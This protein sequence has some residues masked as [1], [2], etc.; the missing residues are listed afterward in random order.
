[1]ILEIFIK[2]PWSLVD[3][4]GRIVIDIGTYVGDSAIYFVLKGAKKV[5]AVEPHPKAYEEMLEN[6]RLNKMED[7]IV[8]VNAGLAS[9]PGFIIIENVDIES[10]SGTYY[11][12]GQTGSIKAITLEQLINQLNINPSNTILKMDCEGCEYDVIINDYEHV[13][14][15]RE[16]IMEYHENKEHRLTDINRLLSNDYYCQIIK[17]RANTRIMHCVKKL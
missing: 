9:R 10:T 12:P 11:R 2:Q 1:M 15:F 7:K 17:E 5:I 14:L 16:L 4:R 3:P 13:K 6:I 8:P